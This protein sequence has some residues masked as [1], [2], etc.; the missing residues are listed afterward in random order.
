MNQQYVIIG[1]GA[2]IAAYLYYSRPKKIEERKEPEEEKYIKTDITKY[3]P[4]PDTDLIKKL[5]RIEWNK[6]NPKYI[7]TKPAPIPIDLKID[8][9]KPAI[10][11]FQDISR[12]VPPSINTIKQKEEEAFRQAIQKSQSVLKVLHQNVTQIH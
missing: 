6:T 4:K 10:T 11:I 9:P 7:D 3:N 8:E 12:H 2:C 1:A 5:Q